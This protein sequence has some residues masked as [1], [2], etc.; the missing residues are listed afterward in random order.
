MKNN[1]RELTANELETVSGGY[2]NPFPDPDP[3]FV[4]PA[5]PVPL[6]DVNPPGPKPY[7]SWAV[8]NPA[9]IPIPEPALP[10]P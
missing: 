10:K 2:Y 1:M 9:V 5:P 3:V 7:W 8:I 6:G 4:F